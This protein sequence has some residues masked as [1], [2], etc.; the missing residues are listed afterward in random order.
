[1]EFYIGKQGIG[2]FAL[3][4]TNMALT[5][6]MHLVMRYSNNNQFGFLDMDSVLGKDGERI[7][8]WLSAMVNAHVDVAKDPYI[9]AINVNKATYNHVNFLLR[10]G[11][12]MS[13]FTFIAQPCLKEYAQ[14]VTTSGGIYGSNIKGEIDEA[15]NVYIKTNA[16][17]KIK[18]ALEE[19]IKEAL[20]LT[21]F[22]NKDQITNWNNAI[23]GILSKPSEAVSPY[24]EKFKT[25]WEYVMDVEEGMKSLK[26][27]TSL[28]SLYFQYVTMLAFDKIN[29]YA[30]EMSNLVQLSQIDTKKFGNDVPSHINFINR[31]EQFKNS[32]R[33]VTWYIS[34]D[35]T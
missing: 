24:P 12:G 17:R 3:N 13:T 27:K 18:K 28:Q 20:S 25:P 35:I 29:V 14:V 32:T 33:Q 23:N 31:Y 6:A 11:M 5:Q 4:V 15:E 1:M 9:F 10:A 16:K 19:K 8:A 7:S 34:S 26:D 21:V 2:P 22:D 30:E